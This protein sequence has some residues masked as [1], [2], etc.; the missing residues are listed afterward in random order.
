MPAADEEP[1]DGA[2]GGGAPACAVAGCARA[3][4]AWAALAA[5]TF[6]LSFPLNETF[7][8][9]WPLAFA[10][11]ALLALAA[12]RAPSGRTLAV[13]IAATFGAAYLAHEWWMA[14]VTALGMPVLVA[15]L[16]GWTALLALL[17]RALA[18][19]AARP[20]WPLAAALP[21]ALVA[22][23]FLRGDLVCT[24]YAWFFAAHP[25]VEF[26]LVAQLASLG[27]GWLVSAFA[28]ATAGGLL[29]AILRPAARVRALAFLAAIWAIT[30]GWGAH[31][32]AT[33]RA[34]DASFAGERPA[35]LAVQTDLP[36][37]NK[38]AWEPEAQVRDFE[39]F[40]RLT[41][42]GARAARDGGR[43]IDLALWPETTVPGLGLEPEALATLVDGGFYPGDRYAEALRELARIVEAPLLVG[44]P[45]FL[46]L[47][48]DAEARRFRWDRQYNSAYL[49]GP[50]GPRGRTDKI[51]LTPFGET[52]PVIS[53]WDW[54]EQALL[55]LGA[56]GMT[57]D[58]DAAERPE[59]FAVEV[60]RR[61]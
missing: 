47:R 19:T 52:M 29:D 46:G 27:G 30:L 33:E 20:G 53:N 43:A 24:G 9:G 10:W 59:R 48:V 25:L 58:L 12:R 35:L 14:E 17:V 37:S 16:A 28:A 23:E 50:D 26:P 60:A 11:P 42:G 15:Y 49:V 55:D 40:A 8:A 22:I 57:F 32:L 21:V 38:L 31:R 5:L 45:A 18:G 39:S 36:M 7:V 56:N 61:G 41:I 54:L 44:S 2:R 6:A 13:A 3:T 51:F 1:S 4:V 34:L